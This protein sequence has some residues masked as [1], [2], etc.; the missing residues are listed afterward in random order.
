MQ[1]FTAERRVDI[2]H[3]CTRHF[4]HDAFSIIW[5]RRGLGAG[6]VLAQ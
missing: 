3:G 6:Q 5:I 1:Q 2:V 4:M